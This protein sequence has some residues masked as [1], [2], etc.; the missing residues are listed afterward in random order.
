MIPTSWILDR[1][2]PTK[3]GY[4]IDRRDN[5]RQHFIVWS[6]STTTAAAAAT[7]TTTTNR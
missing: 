6:K 5:T 4:N 3:L 2:N 1:R 7:A